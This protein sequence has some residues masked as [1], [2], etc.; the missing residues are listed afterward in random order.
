MEG[1]ALSFQSLN[2]PIC[3]NDQPSSRLLSKWLPSDWMLYR[4]TV[5]WHYRMATAARRHCLSYTPWTAPRRTRNQ[6]TR[7]L[8]RHATLPRHTYVSAASNTVNTADST[9]TL[10]STANAMHSAPWAS[11]YS[12]PTILLTQQLVIDLS[13]DGLQSVHR[14]ISWSMPQLITLQIPPLR[15]ADSHHHGKHAAPLT[16]TSAEDGS[17]LDNV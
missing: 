2:V 3:G 7:S 8:G 4:H 11:T 10:V 9:L 16:Y 13:H 1:P 5:T 15:N 12:S 6:K 17:C 14:M